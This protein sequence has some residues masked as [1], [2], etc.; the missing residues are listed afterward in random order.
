MLS[1]SSV[2]EYLLMLLNLI[3]THHIIPDTWAQATV[4]VFF[5][6]KGDISL[7][8]S[9]R[10]ISLLQTLYKV[11]ATLLATRL[12]DSSLK[13]VCSQQFG[14]QAGKSSVDPMH[15]LR[16]LRDLRKFHPNHPFYMAFLDWEKAFDRVSPA[17]LLAALQ[18]LGVP[19]AIIADIE[20]IYAAPVFAVRTRQGT[21]NPTRMSFI[22]F[23]VHPFTLGH[24]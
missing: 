14:F 15:I 18:R 21:S 16:R 10:P 19:P 17:G 2:L 11:F 6:Q 23:L 22:T 13:L 9:W 12:T 20:A 8:S 24:F 3:H 4:V 1:S 7:P 5:K